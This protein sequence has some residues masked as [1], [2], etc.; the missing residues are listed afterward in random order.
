MQIRKKKSYGWGA[1]S[2]TRLDLVFPCK[3]IVM[4]G[5]KF[6][7]IF[8]NNVS[9]SSSISESEA[10]SGVWVELPFWLL[11]SFLESIEMILEDDWVWL[12]GFGSDDLR[13][14]VAVVQTFGTGTTVEDVDG[15]FWRSGAKVGK[16]SMDGLCGRVELWVV[17]VVVDFVVVADIIVTTLTVELWFGTL[18]GI[19]GMAAGCL[20]DSAWMNWVW[21]LIGGVCAPFRRVFRFILLFLAFVGNVAGFGPRIV[22]VVTGTTVVVVLLEK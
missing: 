1:S 18:G 20:F 10:N 13:S 9:V 15:R 7:E 17:V 8:L 5:Y 14:V 4:N 6:G 2:S 21:E 3:L 11:Y 12:N 19:C 22:V 16:S